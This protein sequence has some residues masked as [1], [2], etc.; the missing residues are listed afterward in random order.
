[1]DDNEQKKELPVHVI[2]GILTIRELQARNSTCDHDQLDLFGVLGIEDQS[3]GDQELVYK[4]F[5]D[6]FQRH[7]EGFYDTSLIW[8][9][10]HPT[11]DNIKAG[12]PLRLKSFLG[13]LKKD[14]E[15]FEKY[16]NIKEQLA[17]GI[18]KRV[19]SQPNGRECYIPHKPAI[20]KNAESTKMR[21]VYD[22]SAKSN[23]SRPSLNEC[24]E[25]GSALQNLLWS[26]LVRNIFSWS[27]V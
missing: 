23:C 18:I 6:Q 27:A 24:L 17:E 22:A 7:P 15:I 13:K 16:D 12:S 9:V 5:Q 4:E 2:L 25:T 14:P 26:V 11:L 8:K 3:S 1:M 10:A 21:V 20:R 19:T